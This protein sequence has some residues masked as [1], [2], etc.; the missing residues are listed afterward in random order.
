MSV[1]R[2]GP[3]VVAPPRTSRASLASLRKSIG[4]PDFY[5]QVAKLDPKH[6]SRWLKMVDVQ[7]RFQQ[8]EPGYRTDAARTYS[9]SNRETLH[10]VTIKLLER[11]KP[12]DNVYK[13]FVEL[14]PALFTENGAWKLA[15][16]DQA[17][18]L[19]HTDP[20]ML[21]G[22]DNPLLLAAGLVTQPR[23]AALVKEAADETRASRKKQGLPVT[24]APKH[25]WLG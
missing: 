17:A 11:Q 23:W 21:F 7:R 5:T 4:S 19:L 2:A 12:G 9:E 14:H 8:A 13:Q 18:I 3:A 22:K 24:K 25:G 10:R 1:R 16:D 6:A 20:A 15:K